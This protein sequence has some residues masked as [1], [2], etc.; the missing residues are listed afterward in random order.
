MAATIARNTPRGHG[1]ATRVPEDG[2]H[3]PSS[4]GT[5]K[6]YR[7]R[8]GGR[9]F[10]RPANSI[11][12]PYLL[13]GFGTCAICGGSM[14]VLSRAHG[15]VGYRHRV[16]FYGCMT[17]K[18]RG[19]SVCPNVLEVPLVAA[20]ESVLTAVERDVLRIESSRDG[21]LQGHEGSPGPARTRWG[22]PDDCYAEG[23]RQPGRRSRTT[24]PRLVFTPHEG[25]YT[26]EGAGTISSAIGGAASLQKVWWPQR[27]PRG[28]GKWFG[29]SML[30]RYLIVDGTRYDNRDDAGVKS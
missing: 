7:D 11:E 29:R 10:G 15:P 4:D 2:G 13:T 1:P 26:F 22:H 27:E 14:A 19:R 20:D 16:P 9:A 23:T 6:V 18:L 12:S 5:A 24:G 17:R 30:R 8:T 25:F 28:R 21:A 3:A